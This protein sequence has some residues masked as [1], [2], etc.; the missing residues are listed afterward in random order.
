MGKERLTGA[1]LYRFTHRIYISEAN[2][3]S[4]RLL[5]SKRLVDVSARRA[6]R[7]P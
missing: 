1:L 7:I 2:G 4:C 5:A 6:Q 3:K